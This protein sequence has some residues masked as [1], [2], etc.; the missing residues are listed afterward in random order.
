M[1]VPI[2]SIDTPLLALRGVDKNE[3]EFIAL[4]DDIRQKGILLP[5][6]V[7][8]SSNEDFDYELVDGL[9]RL[10]AAKM[11]PLIDIPINVKEIKD[12]EILAYQI[13]ANTHRVPTKPSEITSALKSIIKSDTTLRSLDLAKML[14]RSTTW[15]G[16]YLSLDRIEDPRILEAIDDGA[17]PVVSAIALAKVPK[18]EQSE[19]ASMARTLDAKDFVPLANARA[20]EVKEADLK[21]LDPEGPTFKPFAKIRNASLLKSELEKPSN[22]LIVIEHKETDSERITA[23]LEWVLSLDPRGIEEQ[24]RIFEKRLKKTQS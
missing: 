9:Q 20:K 13:C 18:A 11:A 19:Y 15:V 6:L 10:T 17:V 5:I 2:K 16:S 21:G 1:E 14:N 23:I 22:T 7:R 12:S 24:K 3:E 4:V 8:P